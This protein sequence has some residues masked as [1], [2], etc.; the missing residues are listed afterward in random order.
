MQIWIKDNYN[1]DPVKAKEKYNPVKAKAKDKACY[2]TVIR[3]CRKKAQEIECRAWTHRT[4]NVEAVIEDEQF[5]GFCPPIIVTMQQLLGAD[6]LKLK[7]AFNKYRKENR[8][9]NMFEDLLMADCYVVTL[10]NS[11][12]AFYIFY[13]YRGPNDEF[14]SFL[15]NRSGAFVQ[16]NDIWKLA[17][18]TLKWNEYLPGEG[19]S[20]DAIT[21]G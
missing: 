19:R 18:P 7:N 13:T 4:G 20:L 12:P 14:F 1:Y 11:I 5:R 21:H 9:R 15:I 8:R 17:N 16:A 2:D 3:P 6:V 10:L